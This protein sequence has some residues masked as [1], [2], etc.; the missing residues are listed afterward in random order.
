MAVFRPPFTPRLQSPCPTPVATSPT[1]F[2]NSLGP[3]MHPRRNVKSVKALPVNRQKEES[4]SEYVPSATTRATVTELNHP[5]TTHPQPRFALGYPFG[6]LCWTFDSADTG[7]DG[8]ESEDGQD[9]NPYPLEGKYIDEADRQM[10]VFSP[11]YVR[12]TTIDDSIVFKV[13]L[14]A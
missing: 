10:C 9:S 6:V 13:T 7:E 14:D 11:L 5:S 3:A 12:A 2:S 4:Q 1:N 8:P